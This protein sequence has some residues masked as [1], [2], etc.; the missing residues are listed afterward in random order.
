[1]TH[2]VAT[3]FTIKRFLRPESDVENN[4]IYF[5][6]LL[7]K[8]SPSPPAVSHL[9]IY[10]YYIQATTMSLPLDR[11]H[12]VPDFRLAEPKYALSIMDVGEGRF[13]RFRRTFI[14]LLDRKCGGLKTFTCYMTS[15]DDVLDPSEWNLYFSLFF[16][17]RFRLPLAVII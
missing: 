10:Y 12:P 13:E 14:S 7:G 3:A 17:S 5:E 16:L 6:Y 1:V 4:I 2:R 15:R 8:S 9:W 11:R